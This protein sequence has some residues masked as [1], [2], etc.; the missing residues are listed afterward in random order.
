MR[1]GSFL[2][3]R[4]LAAGLDNGLFW[5]LAA[6]YLR[7]QPWVAPDETGNYGSAGCVMLVPVL[8]G[9]CLYF[10]CSEGRWRR[11]LGKALLDLA[12]ERADG[13]RASYG[14][15]LKRH[16]LDP[17]DFMMFGLP[18]IIAVKFTPGCQ[19]LGDLVAGTRVV[20][21]REVPRDHEAS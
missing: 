2:L 20:L 21:R 12:V 4:A 9:W 13:R 10:A 3:R 7:Y 19:R 14:A 5:G 17:I 8:V 11:T 16:L 18:A 15:C 6:C 1:S